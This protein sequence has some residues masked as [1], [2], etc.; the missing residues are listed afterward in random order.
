MNIYNFLAELRDRVPVGTE[1]VVS[2]FL[3]GDEI[4]I[5]VDLN[6]NLTHIS[7]V[8][9]QPADYFSLLNEDNQ[10]AFFQAFAEE[11]NSAISEWEIGEK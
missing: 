2:L 7:Y 5:R 8:V 10:E 3:L 4:R 9:K 11:V 1:K 6:F